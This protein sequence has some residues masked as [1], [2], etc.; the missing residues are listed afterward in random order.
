M[1]EAPVVR[2]TLSIRHRRMCDSPETWTL[3]NNWQLGAC[4]VS[5][6]AFSA[7]ILL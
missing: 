3:A 4:P 1:R 7:P 2:K 5:C 6:V